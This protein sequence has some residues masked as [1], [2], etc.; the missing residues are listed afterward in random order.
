[1]Q[2][3]SEGHDEVAY[4]GRWCP[5]CMAI[6]DEKADAKARLEALVEERDDLL[7][8]LGQDQAELDKCV[9]RKLA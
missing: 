9:C 6:V 5:V 3:C 7:F 4:E 1:M 8:Q 2:L